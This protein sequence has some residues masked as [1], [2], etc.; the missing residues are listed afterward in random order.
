VSHPFETGWLPLSYSGNAGVNGVSDRGASTHAN[1][2]TAFPP[3]ISASVLTVFYLVA[4]TKQVELLRA[5]EDMR[6]AEFRRM[7]QA[8][9][10]GSEMAK[11]NR[12]GGVGKEVASKPAARRG[13]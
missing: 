8:L 1:Y 7:A 2:G 4:A 3:I 12:G 11:A 9:A 5:A 13:R 6:L 10:V